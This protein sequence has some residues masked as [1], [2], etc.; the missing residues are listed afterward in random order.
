MIF[1]ANKKHTWNLGFILATSVFAFRKHKIGR[2][3]AR[4]R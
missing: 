2:V 3:V 4:F 1:E